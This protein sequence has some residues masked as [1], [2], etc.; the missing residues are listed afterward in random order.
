LDDHDLL[1]K[2]RKIAEVNNPS[3]VI[4]SRSM[5]SSSQG[6]GDN[7]LASSSIPSSVSDNT[8]TNTEANRQALE[9]VARSKK[10]SKS[11]RDLMFQLFS[12]QFPSKSKGKGSAVTASMVRKWFK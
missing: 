2:R 12:Q 9:D 8:S 1:E 10:P 7:N 3:T 4:C 5:R 6:S 11:D